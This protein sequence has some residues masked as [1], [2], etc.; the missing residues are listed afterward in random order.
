MVASVGAFI[1]SD[2]PFR[3]FPPGIYGFIGDVYTD[4]LYRSQGIATR[5]NNDALLWLKGKRIKMVRFLA[6]DTERPIYERLGFGPTDEMVL[7]LET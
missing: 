1:K 5:L 3:Y 6:L 7:N 2:L 4:P